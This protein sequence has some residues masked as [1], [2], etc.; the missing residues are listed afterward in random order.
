MHIRTYHDTYVQKCCIHMPFFSILAV[1]LFLKKKERKKLHPASHFL[2]FLSSPKKNTLYFSSSS[3]FLAKGTS[4]SISR[5]MVTF[6]FSWDWVYVPCLLPTTLHA[7]N[8][9]HKLR[10]PP[11]VLPPQRAKVRNFL[12]MSL[13]FHVNPP[14]P[15]FHRKNFF[16]AAQKE[17]KKKSMWARTKQA[18]K[19]WPRNSWQGIFYLLYEYLL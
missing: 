13:R 17:K 6:H 19:S 10:T 2:N 8:P 11:P 3:S 7:S 16:R 5:F 12:G 9:A 1:A 14:S 15:H 4:T 18:Q